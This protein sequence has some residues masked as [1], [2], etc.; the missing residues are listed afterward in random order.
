MSLYRGFVGVHSGIMLA[1]KILL[2]VAALSYFMF[3]AVSGKNG[4]VSYISTKKK[5]AEQNLVLEQLKSERTSLQR[6]V[7]L[8]GNKSLDPDLLEERCRII[9]NYGSPNEV[10]IKEKSVK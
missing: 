2:L 5:V 4:F 10:I 6:K 8:L 1:C 3:H 9:L 7:E